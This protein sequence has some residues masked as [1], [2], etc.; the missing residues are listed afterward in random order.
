MNISEFVN[1]Y[2]NHPVLFIGTGM[3]LRYLNNSYTW[4]G[5]LSYISTELTGDEEEGIDGSP[6]ENEANAKAGEI[7]RK[8]GRENPEVYDL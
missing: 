1:N 6:Q 2:T 4:D 7:V 3:S 5:L 8:F